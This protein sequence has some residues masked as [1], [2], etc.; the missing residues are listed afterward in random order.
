[1]TKDEQ[2]MPNL[3]TFN[4]SFTDQLSSGVESEEAEDN[5]KEVRESQFRVNDAGRG[6]L[7][8]GV[9]AHDVPLIWDQGI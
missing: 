3:N 7:K 6:R 4:V 8:Y 5:V 2:N 1:M 9:L